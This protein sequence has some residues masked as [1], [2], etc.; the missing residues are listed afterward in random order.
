MRLQRRSVLAGG[1]AS[2]LAGTALNHARAAVA[3]D[4]LPVPPGG[5]LAFRIM[6]K[7]DQI[8]THSLQFESAG[9][10]LTVRISVDIQVKV[11]LIPVFRYTHRNVET[12]QSGQL[13]GFVAETDHDGT[14]LRASARRG[15]DGLMVQGS[16]AAADDRAGSYVAPARSLAGTHWNRREL[17]AP[18]INPENGRLDHPAVRDAG[19][20]QVTLANGEP[21]ECRRSVLSGDVRLE[22]FYTPAGQW[23][24]LSFS[25]DDGSTVTYLKV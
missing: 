1:A 7:G 11:A 21:V 17:D 8:G 2:L 4:A 9:D 18:I 24:G 15:P 12:W 5:S 19:P 10:T 22:L 20:A 25:A 13:M 23:T 6:R 14:Q 16:K 3:N